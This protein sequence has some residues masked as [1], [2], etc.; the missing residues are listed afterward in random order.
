VHF[1]FKIL[2]E[3][4][5]GFSVWTHVPVYRMKNPDSGLEAPDS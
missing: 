2:E 1:R 4:G 3:K 5:V